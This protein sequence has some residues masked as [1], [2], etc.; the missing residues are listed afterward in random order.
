MTWAQAFH[1]TGPWFAVSNDSDYEF[2]WLKHVRPGCHP[3]PFREPRKRP[4]PSAGRR[5][6]LPNIGDRMP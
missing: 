4:E 6:V 1:D 3:R 2:C 5:I